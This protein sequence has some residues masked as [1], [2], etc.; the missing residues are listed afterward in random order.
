MLDSLSQTTHTISFTD[1]TAHSFA[2][3]GMAPSSLPNHLDEVNCTGAESRLVDCA[4]SVEQNCSHYEDA[5][6]QCNTTCELEK[7]VITCILT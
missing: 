1:A 7:F 5:G 6:V 2:M 3:F 4:H